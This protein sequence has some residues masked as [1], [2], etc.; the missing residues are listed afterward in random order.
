MANEFWAKRVYGDSAFEGAS[1]VEKRTNALALIRHSMAETRYHSHQFE[2]F[3]NLARGAK[4]FG[5][6]FPGFYPDFLVEFHRST[7]LRLDEYYLCL[8]AIMAQYM[9]AGAKSGVGGKNDTGIF[10]IKGI[11]DSAPHME[12]L[13]EKFFALLCTTPEELMAAFWP[14]AQEEPTA[15][16]CEYSLKPLRERPVLRAADGRMIILDPICFAE[17]ANVGPLFHLMNAG[18]PKKTSDALFT[19]FGHAFEAYVGNILQHVYPDPGPYLA[20][21]LYFD[22]RE[23][24]NNGIQVADFIIDDFTDIV[25]IEAKAVW[26]QDEKMSQHD[27]QVFVDHIRARYR[28][29]DKEKGYAQL[30]RNITKISSGAWQPAGI[31][32]SRTKRMYP[33][34][35]VHDAL[36]D[37][38]VFGHFLAEEFRHQLQ[39]D[40]LDAD[41]W[42]VKGRFRVA[43]LV[44][45]TIDDLECLESSLSRFTLVDLLKAYS[46][47]TPDR[48]V[49]LNNFLAANSGQFPL[50]HN[51]TLALGCETILAECMRR[52]FPTRADISIVEGAAKKE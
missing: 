39:P 13:F 15:F 42:M 41:G 20:K 52:V 44:V 7:G 10:T 30:A 28:G 31:D 50:I 5:E 12:E 8:C 40:S 46:T 11:R 16:E 9:N 19:K 35:L 34:L 36:L 22:V 6:I 14:R 24:K 4:F 17:K 18:T 48:L 29:E 49:S 47:A 51:K 27:P 37:A 25:V 33:V 26:I 23:A 2:E 32:L 21:R 38:P 43:P 45:M 1:L 3:E